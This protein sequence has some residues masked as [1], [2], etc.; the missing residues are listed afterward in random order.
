MT[1]QEIIERLEKYET[2]QEKLAVV[3]KIKGQLAYLI[4][5][6]N[7]ATPKISDDEIDELKKD[8]VEL[9][10]VQAEFSTSGNRVVRT[11]ERIEN[12]R[13]GEIWDFD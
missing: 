13:T 1:K 9:S 11:N 3:S 4:K 6:A 8:V 2:K 5:N 10:K 12:Y 7:Y